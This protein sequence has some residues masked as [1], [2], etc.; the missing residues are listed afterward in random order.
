MLIVLD[1][2]IDINLDFDMNEFE[3]LFDL[4]FYLGN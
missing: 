4:T 3:H 2:D 1:S